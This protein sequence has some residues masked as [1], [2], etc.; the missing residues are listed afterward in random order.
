MVSIGAQGIDP[1]NRPSFQAQCKGQ[2]V[3]AITKLAS[4]KWKELSAKERLGDRLREL[5][6]EKILPSGKRFHNYGKIHHFEWENPL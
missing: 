6:R 4:A 3:T 1:R 5:T 2:P